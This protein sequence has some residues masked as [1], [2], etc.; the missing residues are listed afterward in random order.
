MSSKSATLVVGGDSLVGGGVIRALEKSGQRV[1]QSTRRRD[2][3][4]GT[5]LFLDFESDAPFRAPEDVGVALVIAAATNYDRCEKDQQARV[6][7]E[8]LIPRTVARLLEQGLFVSFVSTNSVF[9]GDRP[10]PHEDDP[11][12]P[13]IAYAR[14][15][16]IGEAVIR[17]AAERLGA[18]DRL[19]ITRLTKILG[20]AVSPLPAWLAAWSRGS[21]VEPFADLIF[22]PISV[23]FVGESLATIARLKPSGATHISGAENVSY[24]DLATGLAQ[25]LGVEGTL[26]RPSSATAKGVYIAFKPKYS[27]I[28]M[29]RTRALTGLAPQPFHAVLDEIVADYR[30][31]K[32][33]V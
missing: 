32:S 10:W 3:L 6:I 15:K 12:H 29:E 8:E 1:Y 5:R 33:D 31:S 24:V 26:I 11:H 20:V 2:T 17:Q 28:G 14:Q 23:R 25:R 4:S 22:A 13:G 30:S 18:L 7:N 9:G 27:G 21:V 19:N 16:S